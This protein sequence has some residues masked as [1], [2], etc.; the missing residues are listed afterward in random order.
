MDAIHYD[1]IADKLIQFHSKLPE[2]IDLECIHAKD[3][4]MEMKVLVESML[5]AV[6][7]MAIRDEKGFLR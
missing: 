1:K 7:N 2:I 4:V 6:D 3:W 5:R